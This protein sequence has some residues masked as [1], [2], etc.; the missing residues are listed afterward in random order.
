MERRI[1]LHFHEFEFAIDTPHAIDDAGIFGVCKTLL[2]RER[3]R[4]STLALENLDDDYNP[5]KWIMK[6]TIALLLAALPAPALAQTASGVAVVIDGDSLTVG[7]RA[8]RLFGIDAPEGKQTCEREGTSWA[9]GE[10][11][12]SQLRAIVDSN[13][14]ECA[15]RGIDQYGRLL[16]VCRANG[17]ELNGAMVEAGW[18]TAYRSYSDD[19]VPQEVRAKAAR[20]GIWSSAFVAPEEYRMSLRSEAPVPPQRRAQA[21]PP[22]RHSQAFS[23]C[24]IKGN[25]NRR[26]QWIYHLPGMPYYEVTRAEEL[27]C[28]EAQAQAA[29]YRRAI[30]K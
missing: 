20:L 7:G 9:C 19:Y 21:A 18:A 11:A 30:V 5:A 4:L 29:G 8:V 17:F 25:R 24:V 2:H 10:E 22:A 27:F 6:L 23:G 3:Y 28:T 12:A 15:G 16:G 13:A 26:G 14:V 1:H